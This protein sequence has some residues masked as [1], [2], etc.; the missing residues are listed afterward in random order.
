MEVEVGLPSAIAVQV[1]GPLTG[2]CC[3]VLTIPARL[4][5]IDIFP[6]VTSETVN[7]RV[8]PVPDKVPLVA[9]PV[10]EV[11]VKSDATSPVGGAALNVNVMEV[12]TGVP[13]AVAVQVIGPTTGT[14]CELLTIPVRLMEIDTFPVLTLETVNVR[15]VPEPDKVPRVAEPVPEVIVKSVATSPVGAALNVNVMEVVTG[16][17]TAVAVHVI[18]ATSVA[19]LGA[20]SALPEVMETDTVPTTTLEI[21]NARVVPVPDIV[22]LVAD[23]VPEVIVMFDAVNAP[24]SASKVKLRVVVVG[25]PTAFTVQLFATSGIA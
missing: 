9:E 6:V 20:R 3:E 4:M 17:P 2:T 24:G 19:V 13:T 15:V 8:V 16:L 7:V 23:P 5:E 10:P 14:C 11:I 21:V 25:V 1:I 18:G 12:V 22:P